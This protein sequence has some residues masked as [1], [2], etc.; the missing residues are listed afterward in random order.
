MKILT[1]LCLVCGKECSRKSKSFCS[2]I[3]FYKFQDKRI[4]KFCI[5]GRNF[6]TKNSEI[7]KY[8][9]KQCYWKSIKGKRI[10]P[11][12]EFKKGLIPW[13]KGKTQRR[14]TDCG[15]CR[16]EFL[17]HIAGKGLFCSYVCKGLASRIKVIPKFC[18][19]CVK[20]ILRKRHDG[21]RWREAKYCSRQCQFKGQ[22]VHFRG[23]KNLRWRG[24]ISPLNVKIR[25]LV[26]YGNWV[27]SVFS[28]DNY[29]CQLCSARNGNG[30]K[31]VLNADHYPIA[32]SIIIKRN[33]IDSVEK[34]K[35]C[36]ELWD[37]HNGRTLCINCHKAE[38]AILKKTL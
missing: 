12:T 31:I 14:L 16:K 24:G 23:A 35:S 38:T 4:E 32:F 9:S 26:E 36:K 25:G 33:K 29:T 15:Y 17:A 18:S 10:S 21:K 13:N 30:K 22:G 1:K 6:K 19:I 7:K 20:E 8:C 34:A 3:C 28:R 37:I 2:R 5:C 27:K 11:V